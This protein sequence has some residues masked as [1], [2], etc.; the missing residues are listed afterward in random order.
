MRSRL[1]TAL[2]FLAGAGSLLFVQWIAPLVGRSADAENLTIVI[3]AIT[4]ES[5]SLHRTRGFVAILRNSGG[6]EL[7]FPRMWLP[8]DGEP[9][10]RFQV[11]TQIE[12]GTDETVFTVVLEPGESPR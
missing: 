12:P 2:A 9:N 8:S 6:R 1:G 3:P 10:G 4:S 7:E 5:Y 11:R